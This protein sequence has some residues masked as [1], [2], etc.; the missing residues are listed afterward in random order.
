MI[1]KP[2]FY[3]VIHAV[4]SAGSPHAATSAFAKVHAFAYADSELQATEAAKAYVMDLLWISTS[5]EHIQRCTP[6]LPAD[7]GTL[8]L[9]AHQRAI[10]RGVGAYFVAGTHE[11]RD[12]VEIGPMG[13]PSGGGST[14]RH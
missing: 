6:E 7:S 1:N 4:P 12:Y 2:L 9:Q 10:A 3:I 8:G 11:E 13:S 14:E 5:V